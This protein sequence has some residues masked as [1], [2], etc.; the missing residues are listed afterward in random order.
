LLFHDRAINQY[1][2]PLFYGGRAGDRIA[3]Y[4]SERSNWYVDY[5]ASIIDK[6]KGFYAS[7]RDE[8]IFTLPKIYITRTGNPILAFYDSNTYAS[9][10]FFALQ[11][12][13][14]ENNSEENLKA[15]L[16]L[17][18]SSL[19]NYYIRTF[20]SPRLGETYIETKIIHLNRIPVSAD[21]LRQN[22]LFLSL[23]NL[24]IIAVKGDLQI[25]KQFLSD[26]IDACVMECYFR[27]HMAERDLLFHDAVAPNLASYDPT[28][29]VS[30]QRDFLTHLHQ[31]LNAPSHP[32]RK[33]LDRIITDSPD[34]LGVILREGKV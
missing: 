20:A 9:N 2:K 22:S 24:I 28:A 6:G 18:L 14:Y 26:L 29:S 8:R 31:T 21:L 7:L 30:V 3:N 10:N 23:T 16:P 4:Y 34:L 25:Q 17:I 11:F 1:C 27:E 5:R 12:R 19:A 13:D 15:I 33:H 32:I